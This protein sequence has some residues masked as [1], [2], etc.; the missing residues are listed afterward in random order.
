MTIRFAFFI[1]LLVLTAC[2]FFDSTQGKEY[3]QKNLKKIEIMSYN[4]EN[5]FDTQHDIHDGHHLQDYM[6]LP[7]QSKVKREGCQSISSSYWQKKCFETDWSKDKLKIKISQLGRVIKRG[8]ED[9]LPDILAVT[10]IENKNVAK[11]L[12]KSLGYDQFMITKGKD[13]R[14]IEVA[15]FY[16]KSPEHELELVEYK[17]HKLP[18]RKTRSILE[19]E[20]SFRGDG[21]FVVYVNHWPSQGA[22]TFARVEQAE[23][24]VT[25]IKN[26]SQK[27]GGHIIALGDFNTLENE[28]PHPFRD[29]L[30]EKIDLLDLHQE[31]FLSNGVE[32]SQK[33]ALP[34]GTYFYAPKMSWN[35]LDRVFIGTAL[36]DQSGSEVLP[37]SYRIYAPEFAGEKF[38]QK[39][40]SSAHYGSVVQ[41][42]PKRSNFNT[43]KASKAG[44]SDHFPIVFELAYPVED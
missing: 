34:L 13:E 28:K 44:F 32:K 35:L 41:N 36:R 15:I 33:T 14:G 19:A 7:K 23:L 4:L 20:F 43:A 8:E 10:E 30:Q 18:K 2:Q 21:R 39:N 26:K 17:E 24:L 42:I 12:A 11:Q 3:R 9:K 25:L 6:Y 29:I 22:P 16:N 1:C 38:V 27:V 5:L 40:K 31:F 37:E